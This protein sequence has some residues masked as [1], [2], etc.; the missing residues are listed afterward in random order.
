MNI[1]RPGTSYFPFELAVIAATMAT[2]F[3]ITTPSTAAGN[4]VADKKL[5]ASTEAAKKTGVDPKERLKEIEKNRHELQTRLQAARLQERKA[6]QQLNKIK[7][8]LNNTTHELNSHQHQLK[9][10]ERTLEQTQDN[11]T[12]TKTEEQRQEELAGTRLKEIYEGQRLGLVE[13]LFEVKSL[14]DILDLMYYQE[15]IAAQDCQI[16]RLLK[17]RALALH[18]QKNRLGT[19]KNVLGDLVSEFARKAMALNKEKSAQEQI[20]DKMRTQRAFY[21]QAERQ[22]AHESMMLEQQ[23]MSMINANKKSATPAAEGSGSLSMPIKAAITS[24]FGWRRH[25]IFGVRKF[26]TGID[27]AGPN[28]SPIKAADGGNVL[29]AGWY[30]GYGKVVI[31][32]HGNGLATL[33]AHMSKT[34]VSVGAN[35]KKGDIVGYE[36][37][38][39]FS[40]GPHLHFEVRVDGKPNNPLNYV[41]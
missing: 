7:S 35:V 27:L 5:L 29:Y 2:C 41:K 28:R 23:I 33:Y 31:V 24:P 8:K 1:Q 4:T 39:G 13:M 11:L 14:Q 34:A 32:N 21:E 22:L 3:F 25:P 30:G 38:T 10:T 17:E 12:R 40:T 9:K 19:Q 16:I 6:L 37:T 36:G 26:H 20:A 15:K 18:A